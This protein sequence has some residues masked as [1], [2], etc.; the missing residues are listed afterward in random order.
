[1]RQRSYGAHVPSMTAPA[2]S[3]VDAV[4]GCAMLVKREVIDAIGLLD[5]EY[6]FSFEDLDW[7]FRAREAGF[8]TVLAAHATAYHEG[9]RSMG[10]RSPQRLYYAARNHLRFA[11][12]NDL[13]NDPRGRFAKNVKR[14]LGS[15]PRSFFIIALNVAHAVRAG[16][17]NLP[18]RLAAVAR[19][20]RDHFSGRYGKRD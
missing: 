19:G 20:T 1:M 4:S 8:K 18:V 9:G 11:G 10:P 16:G 12:K 7:C 6:F 17:G 3:I 15:F 14:P 13:G 5:E 2:T